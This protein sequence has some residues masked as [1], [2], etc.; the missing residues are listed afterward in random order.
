MSFQHSVVWRRLSAVLFL[1][2]LVV[3]VGGP[4]AASHG[5]DD[6]DCTVVDTSTAGP[7]EGMTNDTPDVIVCR[8]VA[9][10]GSVPDTHDPEGTVEGV[11]AVPTRIDAGAGAT[12]P[13]STAV[14][15]SLA[16]LVT[17]LGGA[18]AAVRPWRR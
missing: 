18:L 3:S 17:L 7:D 15:L 9:V 5:T 1:S 8:G 13:A 4:A 14:P 16:A 6:P 12:A 2:A 10:P 11:D